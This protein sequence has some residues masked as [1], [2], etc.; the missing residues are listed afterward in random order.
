MFGF[1]SQD[2]R[3]RG[4]TLGKHSAKIQSEDNARLQPMAIQKAEPH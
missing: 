1:T 4:D 3:H 2:G